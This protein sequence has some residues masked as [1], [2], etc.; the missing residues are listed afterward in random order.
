MKKIGLLLL[1]ALLLIS[2][3]VGVIAFAAEQ[4]EEKIFPESLTVDVENPGRAN[5]WGDSGFMN[6]SGEAC[7]ESIQITMKTAEKDGYFQHAE[8]GGN[9]YTHISLYTKLK[10]DKD[11]TWHTLKELNETKDATGKK[12][13][14]EMH[15]R[16]EILIIR[17]E[18]V[19]NQNTSTEFSP[20]DVKA[21]KFSK[22]MQ[23]LVKKSDLNGDQWNDYPNGGA[24]EPSA[25]T[26]VNE[27]IIVQF[28]E[29]SKGSNNDVF[30]F[31]HELGEADTLAVKTQ[32]AKVNYSIG[33]TFDASGLLLT[34]TVGGVAQDIPLNA[35]MVSVENK[36]F[37]ETG[38]QTV[39][40]TYGGKSVEIPVT[41]ADLPLDH[42]AITKMPT[43]T[44]YLT[45]ESF[46]IS[47]MEV[48]AYPTETE[49][50]GRKLDAA[51]FTVSG[52][53]ATKVGEQ[54]VTVNYLDK[55]A[56][57][58][59]TVSAPVL[60]NY[61]EFD[62]AVWPYHNVS[63]TTNINGIE[64]G[65]TLEI[66]LA[67]QKTDT[68]LYGTDKKT[69]QD[70]HIELYAKLKGDSEYKWYTVGE[71]TEMK[72][73]NQQPYIAR[74][75][76]R[77]KTLILYFDTF[78]G[79]NPTNEFTP[80]D[81]KAVK[82]KAGMQWAAQYGDQNWTAGGESAIMP[83]E[84]GVKEDIVLQIEQLYH[85]SASPTSCDKFS[86]Y[87]ETV[88]TLAVKTQ[89]NKKAY[90]P[91]ETFEPAGMVLLATKD[92]KTFEVNGTAS[93]VLYDGA[94]LD[95]GDKS[96]DVS[97]GGKTVSIKIEVTPEIHHIAVEYEPAKLDYGLGEML[98]PDLT[99][100]IVKAYESDADA[101]WTIENSELEISGYDM[102]VAGKYTVKINYRDFQTSFEITVT[103]KN[104]DKKMTFYS[105]SPIQISDQA[106]TLSVRFNFENISVKTGFWSLY[107]T[108]DATNVKEK[109]FLKVSDV[110]KGDQLEVG[111]WYSVGELM[112]I[113][114]K[115]GMPYIARAS[116]FGESL[117]LHLDTYY[118]GQEPSLEFT[119][120]CVAAVRLERGLY[121]VE[122]LTNNWGDQAGWENN[123][124][125]YT[126]IPDAIL[127]E[128]VEIEMNIVGTSW[129]RP[130]KE[131][132][133][134]N[135][136]SDALTVK[137]MPDKTQYAVGEDFDPAGL[138]L[139]AIYRDG[140]EEDIAITDRTVCNYDFSE[141][142]K[143]AVTVNFNDGSVTF[144]VNVGNNGTDG[145]KPEKGCGGVF[146]A[147]GVALIS[148]LLLSS[149]A[150]MIFRKREQK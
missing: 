103:D 78:Y 14:S 64:V 49:E 48:T 142:G 46:D 116:Q 59:V 32:P 47:G 39:T 31:Y 140:G 83:G 113:K 125:S 128:T 67:G 115:N 126:M 127:R 147:G 10:G 100:L 34:A 123:V 81:V 149:C 94:P 104:P 87:F 118:G 89:P 146:D 58:K 13:I 148:L 69:N 22:G 21:V 24:G 144:E 30:M 150:L 68:Y 40:V 16:A 109:M 141:E 106:G 96:I 55:T 60:T 62:T 84:T 75:A 107:K 23:W 36:T 9:Y 134:G 61:I 72:D 5:M 135:T 54:T 93:M 26:G 8:V 76:Q 86:Y 53:D 7:G 44:A 18:S 80:L 1:S 73:A 145:G 41:V 124:A 74:V 129:L 52:Y 82:L 19:W 105:G 15:Q 121:Y 131:D 120:E 29:Y 11:Y 143:A 56:G 117:A 114:D 79:E 63:E 137:T 12:Y 90:L 98:V 102:T 95:N 108:D 35:S 33:E 3:S 122:Y 50:N 57:L 133:N 43:K 101:G 139:H 111:K 2:V 66:K 4:A 138:I 91:G 88:D 130:F 71:L 77:E 112:K 27:D 132:A 37:T 17:F 20:L 97:W 85:G 28:K 6:S 45:G 51:D 70:T 99:G 42:I 110:Y 119:R 92:G 65:H 136:T 25:R 38:D